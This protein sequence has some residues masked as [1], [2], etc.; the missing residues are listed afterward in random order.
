MPSK[1]CSIMAAGS[2]VVASFDEH[3][4]LQEI[5]ED[6]KIG[7]FCRAGDAKLQAEAITELYEDI[8]SCAAMGQ[9]A[10]EYVEKWRS[11]EFGVS[12]YVRIVSRFNI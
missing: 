11:R 5:I 4:D 6:N 1:T 12:E 9:R 3:T 10:R 8:D 7:K 2:A